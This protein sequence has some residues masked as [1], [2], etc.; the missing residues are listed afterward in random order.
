MDIFLGF[1]NDKREIQLPINPPA[2]EVSDGMNTEKYDIISLGE[3]NIIKSCKL[4]EINFESFFPADWL[5]DVSSDKLYEPIWYINTI[6]KWMESKKPV[7][8]VVSSDNLKI[9]IDASIESFVWSESGG[10]VG[11]IDYKLQLKRYKYYGAKKVAVVKPSTASEPAQAVQQPSPR[12][13]NRPKAKTYTIK[14]GD[15][16][17]KIAKSQLGNANRWREIQKLNGIPDSRLKNLK[18]GSVIKLP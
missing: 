5:P 15:S 13:D 8:F 2:L 18:L 12:P 16:L 14:S 9:D 3:I 1:E 17:W 4:T 6:K 11:D 7:H 10:S